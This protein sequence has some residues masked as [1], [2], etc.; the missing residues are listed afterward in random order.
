MCSFKQYERHECVRVLA[1]PWHHWQCVLVFVGCLVHMAVGRW[2]TSRVSEAG[3]LAAL[4]TEYEARY[5]H[6]GKV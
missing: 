3:C 5:K 4:K 1:Q 2:A 6:S